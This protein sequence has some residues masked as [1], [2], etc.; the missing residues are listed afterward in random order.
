MRF[1]AIKDFSIGK[2]QVKHRKEKPPEKPAGAGKDGGLE[3]QIGVLTKTVKEATQKLK[4]GAAKGDPLSI[5]DDI[6]VRPHGPLLELTVDGPEGEADVI[7]ES[8]LEPPVPLPPVKLAEVV[9]NPALKPKDGPKAATP[10]PVA[11]LAEVKLEEKPDDFDSLN[12]LFNS[13]E[14]EENP[15]AALINSLPEVTAREIIDDLEEIKAIISG[16]QKKK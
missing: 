14:E 9:V 15:L 13:D 7:R 2:F 4:G 1:K 16:W 11:P 5:D 12:R 6:P 3:E 10:A 8:E